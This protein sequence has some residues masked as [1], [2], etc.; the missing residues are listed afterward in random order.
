MINIKDGG[1]TDKE[2]R[3][4]AIDAVAAIRPLEAGDILGS[5]SD[6]DDEEIVE[7]TIADSILDRLVHNAH[8]LALRGPTRRKNRKPK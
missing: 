5:L 8:R 6:S 7:A 1:D 3:I 4:A 2:L